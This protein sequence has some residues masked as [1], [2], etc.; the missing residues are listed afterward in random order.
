VCIHLKLED[1]LVGAKWQIQS[2]CNRSVGGGLFRSGS[3]F[4]LSS[5]FFCYLEVANRIAQQHGHF[6]YYTPPYHPE[7]QPIEVVWGR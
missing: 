1:A 6:L 2:C 4:T 7:L 3:R 5:M